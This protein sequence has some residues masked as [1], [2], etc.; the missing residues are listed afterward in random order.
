MASFQ[1]Y[2][3]KKGTRWMYKYYGEVNPETGQKKP[4][5]KRG[6]KTKKEAQLDAAKTEKEVAEGTFISP[7]KT[8]TFEQVYKQWYE[9][10]SPN[11]KPPTRKAVTFKFKEQ[12]LPHFS[13]LKMKDITRAY[14][15]EVINK[16]AKKIKSV[17]NMKMY[18]NQIFDYAIR[19]EIRVTNPMDGVVIPKA[20][21]EHLAIEEEEKR[22]Y[23]ENAEIKQFLA[24]V[25]Q[26]CTPRDHLMFHF[27]SS[28]PARARERFWRSAGAISTPRRRP[29]A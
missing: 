11:F 14:C 26:D 2:E 5:T 17:D 8:V 12:I 29:S 18:A 9:T 19:M 22:N 24:A 13:A 7:D 1:K 16:M 6:F 15:Q 4:S 27:Y 25:K 23:W 20:E 10:N 28:T 21:E 3:T